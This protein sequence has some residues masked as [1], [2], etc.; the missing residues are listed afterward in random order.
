MW[1]WPGDNKF[2]PFARDAY[3]AGWEW[4]HGPESWELNPWCWRL[5]F[6]PVT[7]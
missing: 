6:D 5:A 2:Y 3:R 1:R 4:L 7:Q